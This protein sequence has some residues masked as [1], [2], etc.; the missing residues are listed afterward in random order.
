VGL[1][2][3]TAVLLVLLAAAIVSS[4]APGSSYQG[5]KSPARTA[6]DTTAPTIDQPSD[7]TMASTGP[8]YSS[9]TFTVDAADPDNAESQLSVQ[10]SWSTQ[11]VAF[12]AGTTAS[13]T[14]S[15]GTWTMTCSASDP[16]GNTSSTVSFT[17]YITP[18]ADTTAPVIEVM[19]QTIPA[20]SPSGATLL[21]NV[22]ATDPDN[23]SYEI[24]VTCVP[25]VK[26][27]ALFPIGTTPVNCTAEDPAHNTSSASFTVT[28]TSASTP[29]P[30]TTTIVTTTT[31][32]TTTTTTTTAP[33]DTT[34]TAATTSTTK[35]T[36][37]TTTTAPAPTRD[38]TAPTIKPQRN[39]DTDATSPA[40]AVVTYIVTATDPDTPREQIAI[41]CSPAAG[42]FF[43]LA[44]KAKTKTATVTCN[45]DDPTGNGAKPMSFSVT[46]LGVHDQLVALQARVTAA[47]NVS[48]NRRSSLALKLVL[49]DLRFGSGSVRMATSQ[50][51]SFMKSVRATPRLTRAQESQWIRAATRISTVIG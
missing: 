29:P 32:I 27:G 16:A 30:T 20:S 24:T 25:D 38:T 28:V 48:A 47:T 44:S 15:V 23:P 42:S 5:V 1:R 43:R 3:S 21:Y 7:I 34:T 4:A 18:Y 6:T 33:A 39:I 13:V 46:V 14:L 9:V 51:A 22:Q 41:S 11:G 19:D 40:G 45:A 49:A 50:L 26:N 36:P 17:I 12:T 31:T 8:D 37:P 35:T 10:C 2:R